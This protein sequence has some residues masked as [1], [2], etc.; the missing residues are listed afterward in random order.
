MS[1]VGEELAKALRRVVGG[2]L[3][4]SNLGEVWRE[5]RTWLELA[6][7]LDAVLGG[8]VFVKKETYARLVADANQ[9]RTVRKFVEDY[10]AKLP[11]AR[12]KEAERNR[13]PYARWAAENMKEDSK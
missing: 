1:S 9:M 4:Q 5:D 7:E 12:R 10:Q 11:E 13:N 6:R 8:V 2:R 3:K